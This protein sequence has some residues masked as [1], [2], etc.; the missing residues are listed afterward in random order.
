MTIVCYVPVIPYPKV[1]GKTWCTF[2]YDKIEQLPYI[3]KIVLHTFFEKTIDTVW[4]IEGMLYT[5]SIIIP[6]TALY[7]C[8]VDA[9][10]ALDDII[11]VQEET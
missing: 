8:E 2:G 1:S 3:Q 5:P 4:G 10:L 6:S 9:R 7:S 11:V